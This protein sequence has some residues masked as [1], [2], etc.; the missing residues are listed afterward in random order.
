MADEQIVSNMNLTNLPHH[1]IGKY[2][3][4][5]PVS[6]SI[7]AKEARECIKDILNRNKTP[8]LEGGSPFYISQIFNPNLSNFNDET[9]FQARSVAR[10]IIRMDGFDFKK[11]FER[12]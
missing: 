8:V 2:D 1:F 9:F 3:P 4:L 12:S 11:S 6:S 5:N 7:Y 10:N